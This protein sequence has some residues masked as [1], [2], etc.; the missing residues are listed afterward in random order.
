[1]ATPKVRFPPN[2]RLPWW[3]RT[4]HVDPERSPGGGPMAAPKRS[5]PAAS[6]IAC[7]PPASGVAAFRPPATRRSC[8]GKRCGHDRAPRH[9]GPGDFVKV[10]YGG[11][12]HTALLRP[13]FLDWLGLS[14]SHLI[15][16][17]WRKAGG[18]PL[19]P[20]VEGV[21]YAW[22]CFVCCFVCLPAKT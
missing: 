9:L 22:P 19:P 18:D 5:K 6:I 12:S 21:S 10:D 16:G 11:C 1:M 4:A 2:C 17:M 7:R 8:R 14:A 15:A 3:E 13:E 20:L